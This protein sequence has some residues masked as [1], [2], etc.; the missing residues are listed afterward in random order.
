MASVCCPSC[1]ST[2]I[3]CPTRQHYRWKRTWRRIYAGPAT[4]S[5]ADTE[6]RETEETL[7]HPRK[8]AH[9]YQLPEGSMKSKKS[10]RCLQHL[11]IAAYSL[12]AFGLLL[13]YVL[14]FFA[15]NV[16]E[17]K[18]IS[19]HYYEVIVLRSFYVLLI[20]SILVTSSHWFQR[21][22]LVTSQSTKRL[23][24]YIC[25]AGVVFCVINMLFLHQYS[26]QVNGQ[27]IDGYDPNHLEST[28]MNTERT[29][30]YTLRENIGVVL[31]FLNCIAASILA[32]Q[33]PGS[34]T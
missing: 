22:Q 16:S 3:R 12:T 15:R 14:T 32:R 31:A 1:T 2:L 33:A 17:Q 20:I 7:K 27:R 25:V 23:I 21:R 6:S 8:S 11:V 28:L 24:I 19:W 9:C 26:F 18:L 5:P 4:R 13:V 30:R 29:F 10:N 34:E